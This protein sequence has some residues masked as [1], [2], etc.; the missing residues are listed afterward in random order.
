MI[1]HHARARAFA[2]FVVIGA[3][4]VAAPTGSLIAI[5]GRTLA[6][7]NGLTVRSL[8]SPFTNG[9]GQVG[10]TGTLNDGAGG[11]FTFVFFN[12]QIVF[13]TPDDTNN[14]VSGGESTMGVSDSGDFIFSPSVNGGDAV[15]TSAGPL[16]VNGDPAPGFP[17]QTAT[18]NSRPTMLPD[19]TAHWIGGVTGI[20]Q[21]GTAGRAL[22]RSSGGTI[23]PLLASG[24]VV[25]GVEISAT[26]VDF[27][28]QVSDNASNLIVVIDSTGPTTSDGYVYVNGAF[29]AQEGQV[30]TGIGAEVYRNF[31]H[32]SVNNA[33]NYAFSGDTSVATEFISY[34]GS[35]V[36]TRNMVID[37]FT[38]GASVNAMSLNNLNQL[39]YIW[40]GTTTGAEGLFFASDAANAGSTSTL[41]LAVGDSIELDG[42]LFTIDDFN[43]SGV[44]GP[45]LD[46]ADDGFVFVE[47]D[48]LD[49]G[50]AS[51]EAIIRIAVPS[52]GAV[53]MLALAGVGALR[54]R[55]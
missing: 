55:R 21:N 40:S 49:K 25:N 19:G 1:R 50:G 12:D 39:A 44:I 30:A 47:V 7:S 13:S 38:L 8:N 5:E 36:L 16:L 22:Y 48:L 2:A 4:A 42:E 53:G 6:G 35:A 28:Y 46:L 11:F 9:L 32:V 23:T 24:Q 10:F 26:G 41:L 37:G 14:T 43:A 54:R 31:D 51:F 52:P 33:G 29:V 27:D 15:Y 45:G 18:F 34:N 20:G 17:G 3:S